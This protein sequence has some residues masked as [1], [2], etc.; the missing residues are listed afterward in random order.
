[1]VRAN[2][3]S[4]LSLILLLLSVPLFFINI[5]DVHGW[6][7]DFS[8]YIRE[9]QNIATG[10]PFYQSGYI[11]NK[12]NPVY[13]PP[14]Y[15]PEL[16]IAA[17]A[18]CESDVGLV[19]H[20]HVL[21]QLIHRRMSAVCFV[22][23]LSVN[24]QAW[25]PA[26]CIA[27]LISYSGFMIGMKG[28]VLADTSCLFIH[29]PVSYAPERHHWLLAKHIN[30][31]FHRINGDAWC[32]RSPFFCCLPKGL[33]CYLQ[34]LQNRSGKRLFHFDTLLNLRRYT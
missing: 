23:L 28:N 4:S 12:Y 33:P 25:F 17:G 27:V 19:I 2:K 7:D 6:G 10:K 21:F 34:F 11:F 14:Q 24:R 8:Q 26:I 1:M 18:C 13:A 30:I 16:S 31:D 3:Y 9:A 32:V 29:H 5:H 22:R 20:A 15:P